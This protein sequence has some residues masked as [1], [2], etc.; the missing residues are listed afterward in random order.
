LVIGEV[1]KVTWTG[2]F[3]FDEESNPKPANLRSFVGVATTCTEAEEGGRVAGWGGGKI[4]EV[5]V[6][7]EGGGPE[8]VLLGE[9][10][11]FVFVV[12]KGDSFFDDD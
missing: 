5:L 11:V 6:D 3:C 2:G 1:C 8:G 7:L 4:A 10:L 12:E 9:I